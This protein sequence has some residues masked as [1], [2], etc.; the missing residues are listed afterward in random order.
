VQRDCNTTVRI[1][2]DGCRDA[3]SIGA[4]EPGTLASFAE[5]AAIGRARRAGTGFRSAASRQPTIRAMSRLDDHAELKHDRAQRVVPERRSEEESAAQIVAEARMGH[6]K[7]LGRSS[8]RSPGTSRRCARRPGGGADGISHSE[9]TI[10]GL[11]DRRP[12]RFGRFAAQAGRVY[13]GPALT[14][15]RLQPSPIG[16]RATQLPIVRDGGYQSVSRAEL[17]A[18]GSRARRA[19]HV[20]SPSGCA[21][22]VERGSH[23]RRQNVVG[24]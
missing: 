3:Q 9:N 22:R 21:A 11:K 18:A 5:P 4:R 1:A 2:D 16:Y 8:T 10:A 19:R 6:R 24:T 20:L 17:I 13:S 23:A 14:R 7:P 12:T 15:S